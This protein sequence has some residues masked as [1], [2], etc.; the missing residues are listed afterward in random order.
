MS[1]H[2]EEHR[3]GGERGLSCRGEETN[4]THLAPRWS[5]PAAWLLLCS[6]F[7]L[8]LHCFYV[9][10]LFHLPYTSAFLLL[11]TQTAFSSRLHFVFLFFISSA[12]DFIILASY[13]GKLTPNAHQM[14]CFWQR[15]VLISHLQ[16]KDAAWLKLLSPT[17]SFPDE[18]YSLKSDGNINGF[19]CLCDWNWAIIMD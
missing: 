8:L 12:T 1:E 11:K 10:S 16:R 14:S 17:Q 4:D 6:L 18:R 5:F 2:G 9:F 7:S 19:S 13:Y 15:W 3:Q